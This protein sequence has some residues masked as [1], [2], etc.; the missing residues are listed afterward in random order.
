MSIF[1][2]LANSFDALSIHNKLLSTIALLLGWTAAFIILFFP[3]VQ[4]HFSQESLR[5]EQAII[6]SYAQ[7]HPSGHQKSFFAE[8]ESQRQANLK[9][10]L[11]KL[12]LF[13]LVFSLVGL[14]TG[15]V[16]FTWVSKRITT[17]IRRLQAAA[18]QAAEGNFNVEVNLDA[19]DEVG[20]LARG[21]ASMLKSVR[22]AIDKLRRMQTKQEEGVE[23]LLKAMTRFANGDLCVSVPDQGEDA[24]AH[25]GR[26]FNQAVQSLRTLVKEVAREGELLSNSAE[27]LT[28]ISSEMESNASTTST[29]SV[30][31]LATAQ[32]LNDSIQS[33][34]SATEEMGASVQEIAR[35]S[36]NAAEVAAKAVTL[37]RETSI[38]KAG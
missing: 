24:M 33:V 35:S 21:F 6:E 5:S 31:S 16:I 12:R 36:G 8:L 32:A 37:A 28:R 4:S 19:Q 34:S 25:L 29:N 9:Q 18:L 26:G 2:K 38:G 17:P 23:I 1:S 30:Q 22:S 13:S 7:E 11:S 3:M 20:D 14:A 10:D 27:E 15:L